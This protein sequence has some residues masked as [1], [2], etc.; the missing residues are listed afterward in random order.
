MRRVLERTDRG[1]TG[2][3]AR[4]R[5]L[6]ALLALAVPATAL[7]AAPAMGASALKEEFAP[8]TN[9][10]VEAAQWCV[11]ATTR[12]GEFKLD[13]KTTKIQNPVVLQ[14]VSAARRSA[15]SRCSRR[16]ASTR[17]R[18]CRRKCPVA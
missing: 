10:P 2:R 7:T 1:P 14:G 12:S 13:L 4:R 15:N 8:F 16:S 11:V 3:R 6:L 18:R 9:C 5:M 17:S